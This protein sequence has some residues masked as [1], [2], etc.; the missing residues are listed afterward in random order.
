VL[1]ALYRRRHGAHRV[2]AIVTIYLPPGLDTNRREVETA[3]QDLERFHRVESAFE[4][5]H[6]SIKVWQITGE[7][8][9]F[10]ERGRK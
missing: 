10:V 2:D 3:L 5:P 8:I 7:G 9:T 6:S 1:N 4:E